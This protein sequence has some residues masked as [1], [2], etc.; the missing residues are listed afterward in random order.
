MTATF[1][2]SCRAVH[3]EHTLPAR[4]HDL[5]LACLRRAAATVE[6]VAEYVREADHGRLARALRSGLGAAP[7]CDEDE[8]TRAE[9]PWVGVA[10]DPERA[11]ALATEVRR[12]TTARRLGEFAPARVHLQGPLAAAGEPGLDAIVAE[13][14]YEQA[15]LDQR[16]GDESGMQDALNAAAEAGADAVVFDTLNQLVF[17]AGVRRGD[18]GAAQAYAELA[19]AFVGPSGRGDEARGAVYLSL[20]QGRERM[21]DADRAREDLERAR[22]L[23]EAAGAVNEPS[24]F[25]M[26]LAQG[27]LEERA[28]RLAAAEERYEHARATLEARLGPHHPDLAVALE[29]LAIVRRKRGRFEAALEAAQQ[30]LALRRRVLRPEHAETGTALRELGTVLIELGRYAEAE[31]AVREAIAIHEAAGMQRHVVAEMSLLAEIVRGGGDVDAALALTRGAI[32]RADASLG[33]EHTDLALLLLRLAETQMERG[34][35]QEAVPS[36]ERALQLAEG[37]DDVVTRA[38]I[39]LALARA[40]LASGGDRA[41]AT[42][43]AAQAQSDAAAAPE[44]ASSSKVLAE[45]PAVL[46]TAG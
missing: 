11:G 26:W 22:T 12:A 43:L 5:R 44:F 39:A 29:Y 31:T 6:G 37:T 25:P 27:V 42:A 9:L 35:A 46:R 2:A 7:N 38:R 20:A 16:E 21:G 19:L 4:E 3:V 28:G 34:A 1:A 14:L 40:L 18:L 24:R 45:V 36:L 8:R 30:C 10:A 17:E 33:A 13:A 32:D 15:L 41:R 23:F